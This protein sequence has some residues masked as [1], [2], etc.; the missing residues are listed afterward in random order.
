MDRT[1]RTAIPKTRRIV[2][3]DIVASS[4]EK[5]RKNVFHGAGWGTILGVVLAGY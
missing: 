2:A 3:S 1:V 4:S 5:V